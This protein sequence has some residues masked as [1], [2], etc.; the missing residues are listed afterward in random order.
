MK[1][2]IQSAGEAVPAAWDIICQMETPIWTMHDILTAIGLMVIEME[3]DEAVSA[4]QR[5]VSIAQENFEKAEE[6][7]GQLF[8][9]NHPRREELAKEA[10]R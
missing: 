1:H 2:S 5:L 8:H 10:S 6:L 4:V 9:L 3:G 7:R